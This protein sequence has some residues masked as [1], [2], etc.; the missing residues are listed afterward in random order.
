M[1]DRNEEATFAI[2]ALTTKGDIT[3]HHSERRH[4]KAF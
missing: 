1:S 3:V 4:M 2:A